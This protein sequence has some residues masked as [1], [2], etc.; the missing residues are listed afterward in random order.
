VSKRDYDDITYY[1]TSETYSAYT[2]G[3][4]TF[5]IATTWNNIGEQT[6]NAPTVSA[7]TTTWALDNGFGVLTSDGSTFY[8]QQSGSAVGSS[9]TMDELKAGAV[10]R[11]FDLGSYEGINVTAN[12]NFFKTTFALKDY[13]DAQIGSINTALDTIN[14]EVI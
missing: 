13:V 4:S 7:N 3:I 6:T 11:V 10:R 1:A 5:T 12:A 8:F 9:F 2:H 14:G